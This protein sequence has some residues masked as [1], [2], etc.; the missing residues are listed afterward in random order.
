VSEEK[1][2]TPPEQSSWEAQLQARTNELLAQR[3]GSLRAEIERLQSNISEISSRL[4]EQTQTETTEQETSS[5]LDTVRQW[6]SDST[7]KA[8][9]EFNS[10]LE[11]ARNE[12]A[13]LA[14]RQAQ[15]E[16]ETRLEQSR[17][18]W[19]AGQP[20]EEDFQK[21]LE[22]ACAEASAVSRRQAEAQIEDLSEQLEA[23]R[24]ALTLAVSS[25]QTASN[26]SVIFDSMKAAIEEIDSQRTQ[27]NTLTSLLRCASQFAPRM[28]FFVIKGGEAVGW[29][30]AG[31]ENGLNDETAKLL[32]VSMQKSTILRDAFNTFRPAASNSDS[33]ADYSAVL[34]LYGSPV[35]DRAAAIPLVIRNK[36]AAILYVDSG[37]QPENS[38]NTSAIE[39]LMRITSM[40]IELL[41]YRRSADTAKPSPHSEQLGSTATA[42]APA[43]D[44]TLEQQEIKKAQAETEELKHDF[45]REAPGQVEPS[46]APAPE[47]AAEAPPA[48]ESPA[49]IGNR[50][51]EEL[52]RE[53]K[54]A[55]DE[56]DSE[57][58]HQAEAQ[59]HQPAE[60]EAEPSPAVSEPAVEEV[61]AEEP[62]EPGIEAQQ[63]EPQ[64]VPPPPPSPPSYAK[65]TGID[66]AAPP[67]ET[68]ITEVQTDRE[69]QMPAAAGPEAQEP[70][71]H[72]PPPPPA[73]VFTQPP[74]P[75]KPAQPV[76]SVPTPASETEQRAHNDAR[77]FARLL[78]SEIKLYNAAKVNDGRR[79]YDLYDRLRDEIDRSRKVYDKRVSPAVAARF[80]YFY[81][82]LVQTL[83]EGDPAKLGRSCPGPVVLAS[84]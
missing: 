30:A 35:P 9:E 53:R 54:S 33:P 12:A 66:E 10:R 11:N 76:M 82:E 44:P 14:R 18:E 28:V 52:P 24:K 20:T 67:P 19:Q 8:Q 15:Q 49:T 51:T 72:D 43:P 34:G 83:A 47:S 25:S 71:S 50:V 46:E 55:D 56:P 68:T 4:L 21:R 23:S 39:S 74:E 69:L 13:E 6:F 79:N 32:T 78:V 80:D 16:F 81:D 17:Q 31:F 2:Q 37:T 27:S 48:I 5:L 60:I 38:V 41:P 40:A 1:N 26:Q 84:N 57:S 65:R 62:E 73:P 3:V 77:R 42:A 22:Q 70:E 59:L 61:A 29:K 75:P 45:V 36:T 64:P 7:A 63:I 58:L